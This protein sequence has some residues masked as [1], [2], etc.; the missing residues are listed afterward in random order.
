[1]PASSGIFSLLDLIQ[2]DPNAGGRRG[3][4]QPGPMQPSP[5]QP[6]PMSP[7]TDALGRVTS[8]G[9]SA[10]TR[11][12]HVAPGFIPQGARLAAGY[13][14]ATD[15]K[16]W[17]LT[18]G[19][20]ES[21]LQYMGGE[22]G[23]SPYVPGKWQP[24][25]QGGYFTLQQLYQGRDVPGMYAR[26]GDIDQPSTNNWRLTVPYGGGPGYILRN[27]Q[28]IMPGQHAASGLMYGQPKSARGP[29]ED[30]GS[31]MNVEVPP[32]NALTGSNVWATSYWPGVVRG[33][34]TTTGHYDNV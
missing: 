13:P 10:D 9:A 8:P 34:Y 26:A 24:N 7:E 12:E 5:M 31:Q 30:P 25:D 21:P 18:R 19:D 29:A 32:F 15:P 17:F 23:I 22:T 20:L 2:R 1:M 27:G 16:N 11:G 33:G 4:P 14:E 6:S 28:L 3:M